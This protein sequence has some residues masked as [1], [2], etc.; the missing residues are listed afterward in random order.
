MTLNDDTLKLADE[1]VA[2]RMGVRPAAPTDLPFIYSTWL[3]SLYWNHPYYGL[4]DKKTYFDHYKVVIERLVADSEVSVFCLKSS[5]DVILGYCVWQRNRLHWI[6]VKR[7]WRRFGIGKRL[8]PPGIDTVSH[9]SPL[10]L[11]LKPPSW[12]FNPFLWS[13]E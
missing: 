5:P 11:K 12:K 7:A 2:E 6:Y 13:Q 3:R 9:L 10:G 8:V 4:I 1:D